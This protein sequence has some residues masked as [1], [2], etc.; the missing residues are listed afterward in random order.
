[1]RKWH[2]EPV[3]VELIRKLNERYKVDYITASLLAR[4]DVTEPNDIRYVLE[5]DVAYL[6]NSFLFNEMESFVERILE[7]KEENEVVCVFGDRDVDGIS[8]TVLLVEEL[9][10]M[11][12]NV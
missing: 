11:G 12:I 2:K 8:A 7:A 3:S 5:S 4:R 10:S 1:M 6:H 9:I